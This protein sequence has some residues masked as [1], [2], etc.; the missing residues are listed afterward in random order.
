MQF[1]LDHDG[2]ILVDRIGGLKA[3]NEDCEQ[4]SEAWAF[5]RVI[6]RSCYLSKKR[7]FR[8]LLGCESIDVVADIYSVD[9][10]F[11]GF[12]FVKPSV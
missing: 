3:F 5:L 7:S 6:S 8:L 1:F 11:L 4:I 10:D 9:I 12:K 2:S